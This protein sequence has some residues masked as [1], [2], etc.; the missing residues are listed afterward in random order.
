MHQHFANRSTK[1]TPA[2]PYSLFSWCSSLFLHNYLKLAALG[3]FFNPQISQISQ[4]TVKMWW[5]L[6]NLTGLIP[7]SLLR[8]D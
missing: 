6:R 2:R 8:L 3:W 7:R 4:I 5:G 1:Y